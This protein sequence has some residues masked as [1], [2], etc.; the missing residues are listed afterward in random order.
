MAALV[1]TLVGETVFGN[2]RVFYGTYVASGATAGT[3]T[4]GINGVY[5]CYATSYVGAYRL[6]IQWASG[7]ITITPEASDTGGYWMLFGY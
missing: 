2:M 5:Y 7:T 4:L 6:A 3:L 1:P